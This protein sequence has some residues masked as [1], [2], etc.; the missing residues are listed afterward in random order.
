MACLI[1]VDDEIER[2]SIS[3]DKL[4]FFRIGFFVAKEFVLDSRLAGGADSES[5]VMALPICRGP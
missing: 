5:S 1:S 3:S 4:R 2:C